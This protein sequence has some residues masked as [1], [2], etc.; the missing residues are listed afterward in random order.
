[1]ARI[2]EMR[3]A[4]PCDICARKECA[5]DCCFRIK[6]TCLC[7]NKDCMFYE[8]ESNGGCAWG[9]EGKCG[10]NINACFDTEEN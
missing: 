1:M 2:V 5:I 3:G 9:L 4:I 10:A 7:H 6:L 8:S